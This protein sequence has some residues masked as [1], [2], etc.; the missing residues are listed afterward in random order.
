MATCPNCGTSSRQDPEAITLER[1]L[2]AKALGT[3]SLAGAQ[4]KTVAVERHKLECRCGW[5]VIGDVDENGE[6][7]TARSSDQHFPE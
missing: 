4:L 2:A 5:Y 3:W 1:V 7:F 6:N